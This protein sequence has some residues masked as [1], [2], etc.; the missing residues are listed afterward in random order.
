M[1]TAWQVR[2]GTRADLDAVL[3]LERS[4]PEAP[5]WSRASYEATISEVGSRRL[6]VAV[7]EDVLLGFSVVY[8]GL[9]PEMP[10]ELESLAVTP[11]ARRL[12]VGRALCRSTLDWV[13]SE[14]ASTIALEVRSASAAPIRLYQSLGFES[15]GL[16]PLYYSN[17]SDDALLMEL[18]L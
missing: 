17:P 11:A 9:P 12:G 3:A 13:R 15:T 2:R 7:A 8:L 1:T 5:H 18:H 6:F 10:A 16:R 4:V 14:G